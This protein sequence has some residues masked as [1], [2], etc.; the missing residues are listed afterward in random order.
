MHYLKRNTKYSILAIL[1]IVLATTVSIF[2]L[3][4]TEVHF[5]LY[6]NPQTLLIISLKTEVQNININ[7]PSQ[8]KYL[9]ILQ[10]SEPLA[11][12][13]I[14]LRNELNC[15]KEPKNLLKI[16]ELTNID[17]REWKE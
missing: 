4:K 15:F 6:D 14:T 3:A 7:S 16:P 12:K 11:Q 2:T 17:L 1:V 8:D 9:N 10:I 5:S 13:I